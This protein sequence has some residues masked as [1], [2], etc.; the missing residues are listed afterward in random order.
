MVI[1]APADLN[2]TLDLETAYT[3]NYRGKTRIISDWPVTVTE[4]NTWDDREGTPRKYVRVR[5][6]IG[7]GGGVLRVRTVNG[8]IVLK[9]GR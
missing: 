1:T 4:T 8:N 2:A 6:N 7:R 5:Q 3:D 9:K